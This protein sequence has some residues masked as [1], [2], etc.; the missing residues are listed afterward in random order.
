M[1]KFRVTICYETSI[2]RD[3]EAEDGDAAEA[4]VGD[5]LDETT[6]LADLK[7]GAVSVF[8]NYPEVYHVEELVDPATPEKPLTQDNTANGLHLTVAPSGQVSLW[9]N[10]DIV[11]E[12]GSY[13]WLQLT[14]TQREAIVSLAREG[15]R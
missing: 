12:D 10:A 8:T 2:F 15:M 1:P 3:V 7:R 13:L 14:P 5:L 6:D 11:G 9:D 4:M